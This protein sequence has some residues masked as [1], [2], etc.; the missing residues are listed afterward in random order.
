MK[1]KI[2]IP[3]AGDLI[4]E[5]F[6]H[7]RQFILYHINEGKIIDQEI[8]DA[9]KHE[10]GVLPNWLKSLGVN[11]IIVNGIGAGAIDLFNSFDIEII[12]GV[13][14]LRYDELLNDFLAGKLV[15]K[16]Y[17]CDHKH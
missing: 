17:I 14:L 8:L 16:N 13:D 10:P 9:P 11:I 6:G 12:S 3:I 2:A 1:I 7:A 4:S 5:H 15:S